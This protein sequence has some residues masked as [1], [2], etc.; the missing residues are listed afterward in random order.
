MSTERCDVYYL[1]KGRQRNTIVTTPW[2]EMMGRRALA[3]KP[4]VTD[5]DRLNYRAYLA[6]RRDGIA[7]AEGDFDTWMAIIADVDLLVSE[8]QLSD[9]VLTGQI[10]PAVAEGLREK[11][12]KRDGEDFKDPQTPPSE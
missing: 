1:D 9:A 12:L 7:G 8:E 11:M 6:C 3:G 2:D 5:V 10:T 4:W